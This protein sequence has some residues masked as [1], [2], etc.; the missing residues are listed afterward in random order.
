MTT[1][2]LWVMRGITAFEADH[3]AQCSGDASADDRFQD[4][5]LCAQHRFALAVHA[6]VGPLPR[7]IRNRGYV[8]GRYTFRATSAMRYS[9][10]GCRLLRASCQETQ[11]SIACPRELT[12]GSSLPGPLPG[13]E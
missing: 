1:R 8:F 11:I 3:W 9:G 2:I 12:I 6:F 10:D 5:Y 4:F 13:S 7:Q